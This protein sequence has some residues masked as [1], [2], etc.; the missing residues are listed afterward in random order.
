MT[1]VADLSRK[2]AS[3]RRHAADIC[4]DGYC[5]R[6]CRSVVRPSVCPSVGSTSV[7]LVDPAEASGPHETPSDQ[8]CSLEPQVGRIDRRPRAWRGFLQK[9][10]ASPLPTSWVVRFRLPPAGSVV[11]REPRPQTHSWHGRE[12]NA[13]SGCKCVEYNGATDNIVRR[14]EPKL[15]PFNSQNRGPPLA[16]REGHYTQ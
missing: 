7:T 9:G 1:S 6:C 8:R 4:D 2:R 11:E 13:L 14:W 15:T 3:F 12:Q 10:A 16:T 5:D